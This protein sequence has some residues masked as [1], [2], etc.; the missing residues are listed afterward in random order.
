MDNA[1]IKKIVDRTG[2]DCFEAHRG[3]FWWDEARR[4]AVAFGNDGYSSTDEWA[5][6]EVEALR[7][8]LAR[9]GGKELAFA[10][11][12]DGYSWALAC[13]LPAGLG[14]DH[15]KAALW[16]GWWGQPPDQKF[17]GVATLHAHIQAHIAEVVLERNGLI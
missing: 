7:Q 5:R 17:L 11:D 1:T 16:A 2:E 15:L 4:V 10:T 12:E 14:L 3:A 8:L 9:G 6:Q 13:E